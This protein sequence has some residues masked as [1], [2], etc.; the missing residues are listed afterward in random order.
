M[1]KTLLFTLTAGIFCVSTAQAQLKRLS[2]EQTLGN[3]N[4]LTIPLNPV[5]GWADENHYIEM[6]LKTAS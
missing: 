3:Q 1:N 2:Q 4:S 5:T 6:T